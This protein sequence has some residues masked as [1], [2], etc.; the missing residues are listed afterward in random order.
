MVRKAGGKERLQWPGAYR[1]YMQPT[2]QHAAREND[3]PGYRDD[4]PRRGDNVTSNKKDSLLD[5]G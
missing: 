4:T 2:L 1:P 3:N 5:K